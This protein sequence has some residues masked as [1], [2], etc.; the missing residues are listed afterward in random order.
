VRPLVKQSHVHLR[1]AVRH[2]RRYLEG[3]RPMLAEK[4]E[5]AVALI[6]HRHGAQQGERLPPLPEHPAVSVVVVTRDRPAYLRT[7]LEALQTQTWPDRD[8]VLVNN[9]IEPVAA[10]EG[11]T[12]VDAPGVRLSEA[13]LRGLEA[14]RTPIVA[15]TDDDCIPAPDWLERIVAA[16]R[17]DR[18]LRGVQGRTIPGDG[19]PGSHAIRVLRPD[20]LYQTCNMAY[21]REALERAGGFDTAFDG[22][23]EDTALAARVLEDGPIGF[24]SD[25]VVT[26]EAVPRRQFDAVTWRRVIADERRLAERYP[27]FYR[28]V[29]G[30]GPTVSVVARWLVGSFLKT[31]ITQRPRTGSDVP[32]YLRLLAV[33]V[34]ERWTLLRVLLGVK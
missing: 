9:G 22:W 33:L 12:V 13:R 7:L 25:A 4:R 27:R 2:P 24:A 21:R 34:R 5:L 16:L 32:P 11:V 28:R 29:R 19:P 15:F 26:H 6:E 20:R 3:L 8:I 23:F 30:P 31:A 10:P 17:A 14:A 18:S 1:Y